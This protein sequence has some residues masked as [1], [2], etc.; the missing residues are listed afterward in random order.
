MS[1]FLGV[2]VEGDLLTTIVNMFEVVIVLDVLSLVVASIR[3][4]RLGI[5]RLWI[6]SIWSN[7]PQ[8]VQHR[9]VAFESLCL[10]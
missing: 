2:V 9:F 3:R 1:D 10:Y 7:F 6:A 8:P 4:G 5:A